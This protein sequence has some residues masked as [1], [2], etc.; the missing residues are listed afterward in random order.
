MGNVQINIIILNV[1]INLC[2]LLYGILSNQIKEIQLRCQRY[3]NQR[4]GKRRTLEY[5]KKY[6]NP[7]I[8]DEIVAREKQN[9]RANFPHTVKREEA[10]EARRKQDSLKNERARSRNN[11]EHDD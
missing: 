7:A 6:G 3:R 11:N 1:A 2:V 5:I 9:R 8:K 10:E 4:A